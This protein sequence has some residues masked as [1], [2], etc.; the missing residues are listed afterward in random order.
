MKRFIF[1]AAA[2]AAL[3]SS[4]PSFAAPGPFN[5]VISQ[6]AA[7]TGPTSTTMKMMGIGYANEFTPAF[8]GVA[9]IAISGNL[10][11]ATA[12]DGAQVQIYWGSGSAPANAATVIGTACGTAIQAVNG[13]LTA[14]VS[15]VFPF[16]A[17]CV[18]T[19]MK[20]GT[21]YWIDLAGAQVTGGTVTVSNITVM[22]AE[23]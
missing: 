2:V 14:N 11:N 16:T 23:Q 18:A 20:V 15:N 6:P 19:G 13:S 3:L 1:A 8:D 21:P 10:A 9:L 4:A 17:I 7:P 12:G 22:A 5:G